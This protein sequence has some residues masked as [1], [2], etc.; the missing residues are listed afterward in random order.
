VLDYTAS[1]VERMQVRTDAD[2][3]WVREKLLT[4]EALAN[5]IAAALLVVEVIAC[6]EHEFI[7]N[8]HSGKVPLIVDRRI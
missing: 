4:H 5:A 1:G 2:T 6:A 3:A 7:R 8:K